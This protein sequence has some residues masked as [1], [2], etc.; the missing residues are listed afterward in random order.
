DALAPV[1][2]GAARA[3]RSGGHLYVVGHHIASLG[4]H[5]PPD[6]DRLLTPERLRDALPSDLRIEVLAA[7]DRP[8][9]HSQAEQATIADTVVVAWATKP[10]SPRGQQ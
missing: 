2:T 1:L 7:R 3:L 8:G 9:D 4:H 10:L 6:P 5:G